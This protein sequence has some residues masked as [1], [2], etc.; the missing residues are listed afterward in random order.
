MYEI[1]KKYETETG[2]RLLD[3]DG[4]CAH[5]HGH[6]YQWEVTL[7]A[8]NLIDPGFVIDFKELKAVIEGVIGPYDHALVLHQDDDILNTPAGTALFRASNG[9]EARLILL[10]CNP[11]VEN[12]TRVVGEGLSLCFSNTMLSVKR[13]KCHETS[14]SYA[15]W[16]NPVERIGL[17]D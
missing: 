4:K 3:Y 6:R 12:L 13:V 14:D 5:I 9:E 2:H 17:T 15:V 16:T 11:T 1:T 10:P 7:S 8:D